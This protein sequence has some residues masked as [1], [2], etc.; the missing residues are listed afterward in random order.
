MTK[1]F[2]F[3]NFANTLKSIQKQ[4]GIIDDTLRDLLKLQ[5]TNAKGARLKRYLTVEEVSE[6]LEVHRNTVYRYI[7]SGELSTSM[8]GRQLYVHE[9]DVLVLFDR[10]R[11]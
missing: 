4:M 1:D 9:D 11:R 3:I 8:V 7:R 5:K 6:L 2:N 10:N